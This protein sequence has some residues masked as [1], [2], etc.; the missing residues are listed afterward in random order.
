MA[1]PETVILV[2]RGPVDGEDRYGKPT[3]GPGTEVPIEGCFVEPLASDE[4][5]EVER[6]PILTRANVYAPPGVREQLAASGPFDQV[7]IR[8]ELFE[9]VGDP[10]DWQSGWSTWD[11]GIVLACLRVEG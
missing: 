1:G 7:R 6:Q 11:P 10:A 9:I 3:Y 5:D 8:G 4:P 2:Q